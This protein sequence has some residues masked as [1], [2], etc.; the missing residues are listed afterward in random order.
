MTVTHK[1]VFIPSVITGFSSSGKPLPKYLTAC[2]KSI[3][4]IPPKRFEPVT[5]G[6]CAKIMKRRK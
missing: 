5:C 1:A 4:G 3:Q 6:E 2:G